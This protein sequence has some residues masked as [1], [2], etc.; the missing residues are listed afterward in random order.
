MLSL[1]DGI[2]RGDY[3][4]LYLQRP[5]LL[6]R[7]RD[8]GLYQKPSRGEA[9]P[10]RASPAD[11]IAPTGTGPA[12][13]A[14]DASPLQPP[15]LPALQIEGP[16]VALDLARARGAEAIQ[17]PT[18]LFGGEP[19]DGALESRRQ[20]VSMSLRPLLHPRPRPPPGR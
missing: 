3:R 15:P 7:L 11:Q 4:A 18:L 17:E 8:A 14:G 1:R 2:L 10:K 16:K 6:R 9:S 19:P 20:L 13:G 12:P 5:G